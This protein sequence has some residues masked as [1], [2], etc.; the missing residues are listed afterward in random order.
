MA[1]R[2]AKFSVNDKVVYCGPDVYF[3][4][5]KLSI[6]E[7]HYIPSVD[8]Y[9]Y[10]CEDYNSWLHYMFEEDLEL[11]NFA[12]LPTHSSYVTKQTVCECGAKH[13]KDDQFHST[14][15]PMFVDHTK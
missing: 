13:T 1:I 2:L 8:S 10:T 6:K 4:G 15:C 3:K 9:K 12:G 11:D 14:W 7:V 5:T